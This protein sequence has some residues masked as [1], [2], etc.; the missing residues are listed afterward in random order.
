M[1]GDFVET[2]E[3]KKAHDLK[4]I[5]ASID[6][7]LYMSYMTALE[8]IWP[9]LEEGGVIYLDEYYSLKLPGG[10]LATDNFLK[11]IEGQF[12]LAAS[13][14]DNGFSRFYLKKQV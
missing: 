8:Y 6:C 11:N 12:K 7:D 5:A 9:R 14:D 1:K 13:E 2:V 10:R 3:S 4:I